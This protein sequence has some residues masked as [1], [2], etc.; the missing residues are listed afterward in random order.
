[1]PAEHEGGGES[2]T[3][4]PYETGG[5]YIGAHRAGRRSQGRHPSSAGRDI[6]GQANGGRYDGIRGDGRLAERDR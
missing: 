3:C 6:Q 4:Q 5:Q 1:M 2:G